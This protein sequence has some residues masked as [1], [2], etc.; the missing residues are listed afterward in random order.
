MNELSLFTGAGGGLL[1][2]HY[3][4]GWRA[5]GYVDNDEYCQRI[6]AARIADGSLPEAPIFGDIRAFIDEGYAETY[7]GLVDVVSAGFPCQPFSVAGKRLGDQD[8]RNMWPE[9]ADVIRVTGPQF[10]F[11]ENSPGLASSGYLGVV[12]ADL[13]EL[14]FD[15]RWCVLSA[16]ACGAPHIRRRLW[17]AASRR[18]PNADSEG[19]LQPGRTDQEVGRR[20]SN[21]VQASTCNTASARLAR[22]QGQRCGVFQ[23]GQARASAERADRPRQSP[24]WWSRFPGVSGMDDGVAHRMDRIAATGNGQVAAVAA[25]A[26]QTLM[27]E[28]A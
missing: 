20:T 19:R 13:A 28:V 24:G 11:L 8:E 7:Q 3:L 23:R 17:V 22:I 27:P 12:L 18:V 10:V 16:K 1:A 25:R 4:L 9:T 5:V 14:G 2:T 15:A 26:W 6:L 21:T